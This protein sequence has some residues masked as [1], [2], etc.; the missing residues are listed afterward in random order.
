MSYQDTFYSCQDASFLTNRPDRIQTD[1]GC[2]AASSSLK[3]GTLT[4][5]EQHT[6]NYIW[7]HIQRL[8]HN[9]LFQS[10][11]CLI[12]AKLKY[13]I[14]MQNNKNKNPW[15]LVTHGMKLKR[16]SHFNLII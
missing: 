14:S 16:T 1:K 11:K 5:N 2:K 15:P 10:M 4:V 9:Y 6:V 13:T 12:K 3:S 7:F 8:Q